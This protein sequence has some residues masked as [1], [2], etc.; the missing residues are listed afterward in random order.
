MNYS[1]EEPSQQANAPIRCPWCNIDNPLYVAYHDHE[2]GKPVHNDHQLFEMLILEG[3]QAGLS[4]ECILNKR[5]AFRMAFDNFDYTKIAQYNNHKLEELLRNKDIVRNRLKI[6][7]AVT[8]AKV[9]IKIQAEYGTFDRY[10]WH[11][12]DFTTVYEY[13]RTTSPLSDTIS[14]DLKRRGMRFV[15]TTII[16]SYLQ[17]IG[18][19]NSHTPTCFLST[20]TPHP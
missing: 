1:A 15:G 14:H 2:W 17:A 7:A 9:F 6:A 12:T 10:L 18:I 13:D 5:Q 11:F 4:W 19:I 8:N 3:F 16:Y 20:N